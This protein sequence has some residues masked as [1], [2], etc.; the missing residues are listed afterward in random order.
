VTTF[1]ELR[2][3][4]TRFRLDPEIM[5][6]PIYRKYE[7]ATRKVWDAKRSTTRAIRRTGRG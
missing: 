4:E 5:A 1:A 6:G 3:V 2:P 7:K